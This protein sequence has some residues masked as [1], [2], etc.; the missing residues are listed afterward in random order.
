MQPILCEEALNRLAVDVGC[1]ML[2]SLFDIFI[3]ENR[4]KLQQLNDLDPHQD[5]PILQGHYHTL[6]S[7]AAS[8]GALR[9]AALA[10][11]LDKACKDCDVSMLQGHKDE[12]ILLLSET[13]D[14]MARRYQCDN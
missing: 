4:P 8:Y 5:I 2:P 3:A 7:S 6:K 1:E 9:L 10:T 14:V 13:L 11:E 12:F